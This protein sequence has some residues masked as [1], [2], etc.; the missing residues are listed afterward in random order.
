M[1]QDCPLRTPE[2]FVFPLLPNEELRDKYRRYLFRD[3]VEVGPALW[4]RPCFP[5]PA[6]PQVPT[7]VAL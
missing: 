4:V 2:D 3:H 1:A 5:G 6:S 7:R